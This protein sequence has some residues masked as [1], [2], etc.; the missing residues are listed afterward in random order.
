M[1]R[2]R[3]K[4]NVFM[5]IDELG[6][7][8]FYLIDGGDSS[9]NAIYRARFKLYAKEGKYIADNGIDLNLEKNMVYDIFDPISLHLVAINEK[10]EVLCAMRIVPYNEDIGLPMENRYPDKIIHGNLGFNLSHYIENSGIP[11]ENIAEF[12]RFFR[13]SNKKE[14]DTKYDPVSMLMWKNAAQ[15]TKSEIGGLKIVNLAFACALQALQNCIA[16]LVWG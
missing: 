12:G 13:L 9:V 11:P 3:V 5:K 14:V 4:S 15:L 1:I 2:V 7:V 6:P 10:D 8:K 16:N